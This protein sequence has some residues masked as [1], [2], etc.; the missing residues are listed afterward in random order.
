MNGYSHPFYAQSFREVGEPIYLP[1]AGGWLIKRQIP[2]T[3]NFDAMGPYPLFVCKNWSALPRDLDELRND[4]VSLSLVIP[5]LTQLPTSSFQSYF[6][7]LYPYKDHYLL[8]FAI[9]LESSISRG[10]RK[11]ARRSLKNVSVEI[12]NTP[13][14]Y[15]DEWF[16]LYQHLVDRHG[17]KGIRA[18]SKASFAKQLSIPGM[19][20]CR[21]LYAGRAVGG[22]LYLVQDDVVYFHLS[23]FSEE[24]YELDAAYAIQ[25]VAMQYFVNKVRWMNLG[26]STG[27][28]TDHLSGL[29]QF[30]KGWSTATEK[31]IFCGKILDQK[32]YQ[33]I[34]FSRQESMDGWF[35]SYRFGEF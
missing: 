14:M 11:D 25:W 33:E 17:I 13:G 22:N 12:I 15:L 26:G 9:P 4:L 31:S 29:D 28:G 8:D 7:T 30:K 21:G 3:E 18:F 27:A 35:P 20:Y 34:T 24:G 16:C 10:R 1:S 19:V 6:D 32:K 23:A 2:D 5:P